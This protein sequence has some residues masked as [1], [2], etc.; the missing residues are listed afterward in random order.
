VRLNA[1]I[2]KIQTRQIFLPQDAPWRLAFIDEI[3]GYP[4]EFDDQLDAMTQYLDFMD[5]KPTIKPAPPRGIV[6]RP[7]LIYRRR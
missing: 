5:S 2:E 6:A 7:T 3:A 1:H 4:G